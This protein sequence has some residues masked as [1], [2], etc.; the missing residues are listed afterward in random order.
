MDAWMWTDGDWGWGCD[1]VCP[2]LLPRRL[3]C[4]SAVDP[5][6]PLTPIH[7]YMSTQHGM[8]DDGMAISML[9][10]IATV[11]GVTPLAR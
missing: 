5:T 1:D 2:S 7:P 6:G 10:A 4:L 8:I 11:P 9:A 3:D